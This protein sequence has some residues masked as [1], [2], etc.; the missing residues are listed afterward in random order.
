MK[1]IKK[2]DGFIDKKGRKIPTCSWLPSKAQCQ[3]YATHG[4]SEH[5]ACY[6]N[7]AETLCEKGMAVHMMDLPG[8]GMAEGVRGHIDS[9]HEFLDNLEQFILENPHHYKSKPLYLL[10]HSLGGLISA[11]YCLSRENNVKGLILSAPLMGFSKL[12]VAKVLPLAKHLAKKQRNI[13][14]PKPIGVESLSRNPDQWNVYYSDPFRGR[15]ISP[16]LYLEMTRMIERLK[17]ERSA[18]NLPLLM[19]ISSKDT[20]VYPQAAQQFFKS[21][22]SEDKSM[23]VFTEAMHELFQE[24]ESSQMIEIIESWIMERL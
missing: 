23:I 15:M 2:L 7:M 11:L 22:V 10:G 13:P 6:Q 9:H 3:I 19:F 20:V 12:D 4:F 16:G 5:I 21:V 1:T 17:I 24:K 14:F 8:H 18:F